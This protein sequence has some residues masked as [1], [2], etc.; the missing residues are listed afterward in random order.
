MHLNELEVLADAGGARDDLREHVD[1][2]DVCARAVA[3]QVAAR[4]AL[5]GPDLLQPP[6]LEHLIAEL[7]DRERSG[8]LEGWPRLTAIL[9]PVA[10]AAIVIGVVATR[11]EDRPTRQAEDA[12]A[13]KAPGA[14]ADTSRAAAPP[15]A[16][17]G[18]PIRLTRDFLLVFGVRKQAK[19]AQ[20][21]LAAAGFRTRL[22]VIHG[23]S[24]LSAH[25][26]LTNTELREAEQHAKRVAARFG[27]R[28]GGAQ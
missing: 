8:R 28:Y 10:A 14:Q 15:R 5:R 22:E 26:E 19:R 2:C 9:A 13:L 16:E 6:P 20:A 24:I 12:T 3:E 7:P 25:K 18:Q 21:A 11:G 1:T 23:K 27:G 4:D 17:S